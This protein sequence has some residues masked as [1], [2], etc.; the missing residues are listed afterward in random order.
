MRT[1]SFVLAFVLAFT[2]PSL[3]ASVP[4]KLQQA[5]MRAVGEQ[6]R[7]PYSAQYE[8][9]MMNGNAV[10]GFVNARNGFGGYTGKRPFSAF[11]GPDYERRGV[12]AMVW[13][14]QQNPA[15]LCR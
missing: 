12:V 5:V 7:D 14:P 11:Y 4:A 8:F 6:L 13:E 15:D 1:I 9:V 3:G 10:C 2:L